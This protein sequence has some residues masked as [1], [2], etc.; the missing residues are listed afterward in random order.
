MSHTVRPAVSING[1]FITHGE[2]E[3]LRAAVTSFH[4]EMSDDE[5]L[6]ADEHGRLMTKAYRLAM[7]RV[8]SL[9]GAI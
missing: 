3:C 1:E 5:A 4:S 2:V 7:E 6:G 8:L 9:M